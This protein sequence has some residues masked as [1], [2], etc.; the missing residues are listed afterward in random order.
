M[1]LKK[2]DLIYYWQNYLDNQDKIDI[3]PNSYVMKFS[4]VNSLSG[5]YFCN[6]YS[7]EESQQLIGFLRFVVIPSIYIS[8]AFGKEENTIFLDA[9]DECETIELIEESNCNKKQE[10]LMKIKCEY[11]I[12]DKLNDNFTIKKMKKYVELLNTKINFTSVI[13][14]NTE[15]FENVKAIGKDLVQEYEKD[16]ML[17]ELENHMDL[18]KNQIIAFFNDI[19]K[20]PFMMKRL[21]TYLSNMI[22]F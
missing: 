8:V 11:E 12:L 5:D 2:Y 4:L 14:S 19:D 22:A 10:V 17:D 1:I 9:L 21:G 16:N 13:L 15:F 7:F 20:N 3:N 6:W 18:K